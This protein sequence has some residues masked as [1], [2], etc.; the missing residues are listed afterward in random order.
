VTSPSELLLAAADRIRDLAAAATPGP[1][2][3]PRDAAW[4]DRPNTHQPKRWHVATPSGLSLCYSRPLVQTQAV[5]LDQV[6]EELRCQHWG[7]RRYWPGA[8]EPPRPECSVDGCDRE[9][10]A[11]GV[12]KQHG[13]ARRRGRP[14]RPIGVFGIGP[15]V[16]PIEER[17]WAAVDKNGPW[18]ERT[19]LEGRCWVWTRALTNGYGHIQERGTRRNVP[20]HRLSYELHGGTLVDELEIDHLCRNRACVNPAHL[21][22][23]TNTVNVL[24]GE[25]PAAQNARKTHCKYGHPF[26]GENLRLTPDGKRQC[27]TCLRARQ[28]ARYAR[29]RSG[30]GVGSQ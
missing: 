9:V 13:L 16:T 8:E 21:E 30:V 15:E 18:P 27:R 2:A 20:A 12:C 28:R 3:A 25:G 7:C 29:L 23:V 4:F 17:F 22:Q 19:D 6:P 24:R 5:A 14:L 26:A 1:W 10:E 11:K